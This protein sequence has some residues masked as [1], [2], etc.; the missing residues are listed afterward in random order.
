MTTATILLAAG[1]SRRFG[2]DDKLLAA[3]LGRPLVSHAADAIRAFAPDHLVAVTRSDAVASLLSGFEI[4]SLLSENN[5]QSD[6]LGAGLRAVLEHSP[7]RI[8]ILLGDMPGV[9]PDLLAKVRDGATE[10][11]PS[12][13]TDGT[14]VMPPVC[15]PASWFPRFQEIKGDRGAGALLRNLPKDQL[16][17]ADTMTLKDVDL[18]EDLSRRP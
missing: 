7:D 15:F 18:P 16:V 14:T 11:Q 12:A 8:L 4:V 17:L 3:H 9:T 1:H 13:A 5:T 10:D 2:A 6:S